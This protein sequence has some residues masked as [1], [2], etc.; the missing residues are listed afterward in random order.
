MAHFVSAS[1]PGMSL[2]QKQDPS[3][4]PFYEDL[5]K[6]GGKLPSA[7]FTIGTEDPLLDD[8]VA[9][10]TKWMMAGGHAILKVYPGAPHGFNR[11]P[12]Q[13]FKEAG[14]ATDDTEAYIQERLAE[15]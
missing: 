7:L 13:A 10:A 11:F 14:E 6:F 3:V 12:R 2:E 5:E 1:V 8:S 9:M 15:N 4:S